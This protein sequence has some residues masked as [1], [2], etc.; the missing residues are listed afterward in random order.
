M[1][2]HIGRYGSHTIE[3]NIVDSCW[4]DTYCI[5]LVDTLWSEVWLHRCYL[6]TTW[7]LSVNTTNG[8][9]ILTVRYHVC[10]L[11]HRHTWCQGHAT[12]GHS[13]LRA[14]W[15]NWRFWVC[16]PTHGALWHSRRGPMVLMCKALRNAMLMLSRAFYEYVF[17]CW[18]LKGHYVLYKSSYD[19]NTYDFFLIGVEL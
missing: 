9:P 19:D 3:H 7:P 5:V 13:I 14:S 4:M 1:T 17:S 10:H 15:E 6:T 11:A 8:D 2:C 16:P 18:C 12:Q